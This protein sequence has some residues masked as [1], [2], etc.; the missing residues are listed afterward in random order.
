MAPKKESAP[1][2]KTPEVAEQFF[3]PKKEV[4]KVG[5]IYIK[6]SA[7]P[8]KLKKTFSFSFFR[9]RTCFS[10][11]DSVFQT[12]LKKI[13]EKF[14]L[15]WE[16]TR[17]YP[18]QEKLAHVLRFLGRSLWTAVSFLKEQIIWVINKFASLFKK[19]APA[20]INN[21][22]PE[23]PVQE[24]AIV[25][26]QP[27]EKKFGFLPNFSV[28]KDLF[29]RL[30]NK[31]KL[32]ALGAIFLIFVVPFF[33]V[34]TQKNMAEKKSARQVE[35]V[36]PAKLPLENEPN[37][38][39]LENLNPA[40]NFSEKLSQIINLNG[41]IFAV[42]AAKLFNLENQQEFIFPETFEKIAIAAGLNDLNLIILINPRGQASAFSP[43]SKKFQDNILNLPANTK[44]ALAE[45][46]LTYLY[47][48]DTNNNQIYRYPRAEGGFGEKINWKKDE[49]AITGVTGMALSE[50]LY[51]AESGNILKLFRGKK[52]DF[53]IEQSPNKIMPF[54]V[55][56][57]IDGQNI[58]ILDKT[59]S[60]IVKLDLTGKILSQYYHPEIANATDFAVNEE[61]NTVY[62]SAGNSVQSFLAD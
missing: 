43:V 30:T 6:E 23:L 56:T 20:T 42:S 52:Q 39:R 45:T 11:P 16:N 59:N 12:F 33:I 9:K 22:P 21:F 10:Q 7:E 19:S 31:Q 14:Q 62:F 34:Q 15:F 61:T 57:K 51:L 37:L 48:V 53:V 5:H 58:W 8:P 25:P 35:E 46:Y 27:A 38:I 40:A 54:K 24:V 49:T 4:P 41:K 18:F 60:R 29:N 36:V 55:A 44:I 2:V 32:Y 28:I 50:N 13:R 17:T 1:E 47:L 3:P 26:I